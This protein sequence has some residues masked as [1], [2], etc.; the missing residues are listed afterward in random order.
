MQRGRWS[1]KAKILSTY[2]VTDPLAYLQKTWGPV[3][4]PPPAPLDSDSPEPS[5]ER[6]RRN[7]A[8]AVWA[9]SHTTN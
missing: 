9:I 2:F 6:E 4:P 8:A 1:K 3:P 7:F 5:D